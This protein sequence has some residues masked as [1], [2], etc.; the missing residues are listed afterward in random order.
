M[1]LIGFQKQ[2][3]ILVADDSR[4]ARELIRIFLEKQGYAVTEAGD[5]KEAVRRFRESPH[6]LVLMDANMPVV[7]GYR[8]CSEIRRSAGGEDVGIIMITAQEDDESV[9]KAFAAGAEEFITKPIQWVVLQKRIHLSLEN[10]FAHEAVIESRARMEAIV[11]TAPDA[12][13][14]INDQGIMESVNRASCRMFGH[15][16]AEMVGR[17]V[18]M[19]MPSPYREQHDSYL[20]RYLTTRN[21]AIMGG[22]RE[23]MAIRK[24]GEIFPIE[25]SISEVRLKERTLFTGVLRDITDRKEAEQ[26]IFYQAHYDALTGLANRALFLSTLEDALKRG[27][28]DGDSVAS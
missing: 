12:I 7:D 11:N 1:E 28:E 19:L 26:K 24:S 9:E 16:V 27:H 20:V 23:W 8:A 15:G 5:G 21:S 18:S 17:N 2:P 10:R 13:V 22:S 4:S 14:V 3:R 25:L 6:D